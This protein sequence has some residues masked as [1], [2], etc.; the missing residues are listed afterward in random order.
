MRVPSIWAPLI[1]MPP[2]YHEWNFPYKHALPVWPLR[3]E[4]TYFDVLKICDSNFREGRRMEA[5]QF[6]AIDQV[7][8]DA[9]LGRQ[10]TRQWRHITRQWRHITHQWR[11]ITRQ[12]IHHWLSN[13]VVECRP[14]N[15]D[16]L[17]I[18]VADL[19]CKIQSTTNMCTEDNRKTMQPTKV[20][21]GSSRRCVTHCQSCKESRSLTHLLS[22]RETSRIG[23][24]NVRTGINWRGQHRW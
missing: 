23:T 5:A 6:P 18:L 15:K 20:N 7:C 24:W 8:Q 2:G 10:I 1:P 3:Y 19:R 22:P 13:L 9:R 4:S 16:W 14:I 21:G 12:W 17:S 11:H